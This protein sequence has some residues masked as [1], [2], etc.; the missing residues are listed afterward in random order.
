MMAC[1]I[2]QRT[3]MRRKKQDEIVAESYNNFVF[4][5][6]WQLRGWHRWGRTGTGP[7]WSVRSATRRC[8]QAH[9]QRWDTWNTRQQ[10]PVKITGYS[11]LVCVFTEFGVWSNL[12]PLWYRSASYYDPHADKCQVQ[13]YMIG[14]ISLLPQIIH[15]GCIHTFIVG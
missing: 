14:G 6:V 1:D 7:V 12:L 10:Y 11:C 3:Q 5:C 4:W 15:R 13:F 2:F 8:Q 9:M